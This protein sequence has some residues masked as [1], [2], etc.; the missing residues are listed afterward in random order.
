MC[1][2]VIVCYIIV[3]FFETRCSYTN[4]VAVA[5]SDAWVQGDFVRVGISVSTPN[6]VHIYDRT[7]GC[8][9]AEVKRSEVKVT[10]L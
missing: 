8:V 3:V 9:D 4:A 10:G 2:E 6:L 7:L 1:V 5:K